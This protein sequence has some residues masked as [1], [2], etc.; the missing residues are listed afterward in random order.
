V[1]ETSDRL[2]HGVSEEISPN[3][4][5]YRT[6]LL[7]VPEGRMR[8]ISGRRVATLSESDASLGGGTVHQKGARD[9]LSE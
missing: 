1:D 5:M 6:R 2:L 8:A 7:P 9:Q 4:V 3:D